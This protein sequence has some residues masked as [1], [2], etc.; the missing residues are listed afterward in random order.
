MIFHHFKK[1]NKKEKTSNVLFT[2][3][4][5]IYNCY[6]MKN[7]FTKDNIYIY[8]YGDTYDYIYICIRYIVANRNRRT[9]IFF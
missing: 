3:T 6:Q 8:I 4:H 2:P 5:F 7:L 1:K 9:F